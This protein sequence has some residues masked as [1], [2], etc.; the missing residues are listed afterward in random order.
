M[1]REPLQPEVGYAEDLE[2]LYCIPASTWRYWASVGQGP[3]SFL[4]G[5]RRVWRLSV[6]AAWVAAQESETSSVPA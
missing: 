2:R 4:L 3:P 1:D 5:R 6:V